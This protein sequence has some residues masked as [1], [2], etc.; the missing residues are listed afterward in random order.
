MSPN[1]GTSAGIRFAA[2]VCSAALAASV[3]GG[4][5]AGEAQA[6][7]R[8]TPVAHIYPFKKFF[9]AIGG[10]RCTSE[11]HKM[12]VSGYLWGPMDGN[13]YEFSKEC[14]SVKHCLELTPNLTNNPPGRQKWK[15]AI[16]FGW[17]H[18]WYTM[19]HYK[20]IKKTYYF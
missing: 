10:G 5:A 6:K 20:W 16:V 17:K 3:V 15:I 14:Y 19:P 13:F 9:Y 1:H 4:P 18:H 8:C 7:G 11:Q 12:A 2:L